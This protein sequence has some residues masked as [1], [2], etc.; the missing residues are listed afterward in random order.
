VKEEVKQEK[1]EPARPASRSTTPKAKASRG[2][3]VEAMKKTLAFLKEEKQSLEVKLKKNRNDADTQF[4]LELVQKNIQTL[5]EK[6][7]KA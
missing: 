6:I 2:P 5:Q 7:A 3:N 4:E 1:K